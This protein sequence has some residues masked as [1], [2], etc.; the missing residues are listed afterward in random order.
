MLSEI[1]KG[2]VSPISNYMS[3]RSDNKTAVIQQKVQRVMNADNKE[4][5][6][7]LILSEGMKF[8]WKDEYWTIVL[9]IPAIACFFPAAAPHVREGFRVLETMPQFYQYWLGICILTAF[10]MRMRKP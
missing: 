4:A 9:S 8:S 10:G 3:K 1:F 7:A 2:L 5:E 6:L